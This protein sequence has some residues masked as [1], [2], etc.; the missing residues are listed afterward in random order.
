MPGLWFLETQPCAGLLQRSADMKTSCLEVYIAPTKRAKLAATQ[1]TANHQG[2]E[3]EEPV[4]GQALE[5]YP[6]LRCSEAA[7]FGGPNLR[8]MD[9]RCHVAT[10]EF[11][12]RGMSKH[13]V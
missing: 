3:W 5:D 7:Y 1:S 6:D 9:Q 11:S 2:C 13:D 4:T 12:A 8:W 10:D